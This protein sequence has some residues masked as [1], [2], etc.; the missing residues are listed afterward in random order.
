MLVRVCADVPK[1]ADNITHFSQY[2]GN[3]IL[4]CK[5]SKPLVQ[6][7][8]DRTAVFAKRFKRTSYLNRIRGW[9][10]LQDPRC[11]LITATNPCWNSVGQVGDYGPQGSSILEIALLGVA[12]ASFVL[13]PELA[14]AVQE[15]RATRFA[16]GESVQL[17]NH[18]VFLLS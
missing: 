10:D 7:S 5:V 9:C 2:L 16:Y 13:I 6:G 1:H 18:S 8:L 3:L 4:E 15:R 12:H 17:R 11:L 14:Q